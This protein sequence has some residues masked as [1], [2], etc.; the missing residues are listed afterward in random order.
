MI[1][2]MRNRGKPWTEDD[3]WLLNKLLRDKVPL[4]VTCQA[5]GRTEQSLRH[6]LKNTVY[7]Q[8]LHHTPQEIMDDFHISKDTLFNHVVP[9]KYYD[10]SL[11]ETASSQV[12]H[13]NENFEC[14]SFLTGCGLSILVAMGFLY[15]SWL[16]KTNWDLLGREGI[17]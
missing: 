11:D 16:L 14:S 17:L 10:H 1:C 8:L 13:D 2:I 9:S 5:L 4:H 3:I 6:A 12:D 15:Y 7:Q